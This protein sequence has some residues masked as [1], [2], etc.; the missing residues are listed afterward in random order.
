MASNNVYGALFVA[1]VFAA[2]VSSPVIRLRERFSCSTPNS[3]DAS[4]AN[5]IRAHIVNC[6]LQKS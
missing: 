5:N 1:G 4:E 3:F 2:A 6:F